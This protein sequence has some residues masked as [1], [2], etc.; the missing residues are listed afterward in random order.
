[1]N[2]YTEDCTRI[3]NGHT[4]DRSAAVTCPACRK[5]LVSL[6]AAWRRD[7]ERVHGYK[8]FSFY[9]E[10][11]ERCQEALDRLPAGAL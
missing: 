11:A 3:A 5:K 10:Q 6:T 7:A 9:K 8:A 4:V 2:H 1:M